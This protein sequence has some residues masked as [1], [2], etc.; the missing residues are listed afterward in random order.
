M[1]SAFSLTELII[2]IAIIVTLTTISFTAYNYYKNQI[3]AAEAEKLYLNII[4]L[5]N[6]ALA[7]NEEQNLN[8]NLA[9]NNYTT[10]GKLET[11]NKNIK[12]GFL[13]NAYG[14]PADPVAPIKSPSTFRNNQIKFDSTGNISAGT[15]YLIDNQ[16]NF[17]NAITIGV[18]KKIYVRIYK[19]TNAKWHLIN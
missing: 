4:N 6:K 16:Q 9:K 14:P 2:S 7:T 18:A 11:L 5:Q 1:K 13:K 12:F 19:F 15:I 3:L 17:M 10:N 8:F